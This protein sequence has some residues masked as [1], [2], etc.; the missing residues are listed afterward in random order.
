M[1]S[2]A[3]FA[4]CW[5]LKSLA[6]LFALA[7]AGAL[8]AAASA[9]GEISDINPDGPGVKADKASLEHLLAEYPSFVDGGTFRIGDL[10]RCTME[11][12]RMKV[13]AI[14]TPLPGDPAMCRAKVTGLHDP[15]AA[16]ARWLLQ[17]CAMMGGGPARFKPGQ[18]NLLVI[19]YDFDQDKPGQIWF[20]QFSKIQE[21]IS[22]Y[23][24]GIG[25]HVSF[26]QSPTEVQLV[27]NTGK[28]ATV[29]NAATL[30]ELVQKHP[31]EVRHY[32]S[33]AWLR[34]TGRDLLDPGPA[35]VYGVFTEIP[36]DPNVA[37]AVADLLVRMDCDAFDKREAAS[38]ELAKLGTP[39]IL[40]VLRLDRS[41]LSQ[42]QKT[43]CDRFVAAGKTR[44]FDEAAD[45]LHDVNF[46]ADAMNDSDIRVRQ[47]AKKAF[48]TCVGH[49]IG[50]D[51]SAQSDAAG[52]HAALE[53]LRSDYDA[54]DAAKSPATRPAEE[55]P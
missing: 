28:P 21:S 41:K 33:T 13:Q 44:E 16:S 51:V 2:D 25:V 43:R 45:A 11:N 52:R 48:E 9:A 46:L 49:A 55:K 26:S 39:G 6:A 20:I 5:Q 35:D 3:T 14:Q 23:A 50:I 38:G 22:I 32:L 29:I 30:Q 53:K 19:R 47:A 37:K 27:Y 24:T 42:E 8:A 12:G 36:A 54:K 15:L 34:I 40:A 31:A 18:R 10:I 17:D 7:A 4:R 1:K